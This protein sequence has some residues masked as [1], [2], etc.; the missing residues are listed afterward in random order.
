M[1][2]IF[3]LRFMSLYFFMLYCFAGV[4]AL[5]LRT[6]GDKTVLAEEVNP[7]TGKFS[8]LNIQKNNDES[9]GNIKKLSNNVRKWKKSAISR[10]EVQLKMEEESMQAP[11][12]G[13]FRRILDAAGRVL[14]RAGR[15]LTDEKEI[16]QIAVSSRAQVTQEEIADDPNGTESSS[17]ALQGLESD[18]PNKKP[19]PPGFV[20][21]QVPKNNQ[22]KRSGAFDELLK[23]VDHDDPPGSKNY[24]RS[25]SSSDWVYEDADSK[26]VPILTLQVLLGLT[27]FM[28]GT[29][30]AIV[31]LVV[32][33]VARRIITTKKA[34][35][36]ESVQYQAPQTRKQFETCNDA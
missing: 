19:V 20:G 13:V 18:E 25:A 35:S 3:D 29:G 7:M 12:P 17:S 31:L 2:F 16:I 6:D 4:S 1:Q 22:I 36:R 26:D 21:E 30:T 15:R 11:T 10:A 24:T 34:R 8:H 5:T 33:G 9:N 23:D 32:L 14:K 27:L 28:V